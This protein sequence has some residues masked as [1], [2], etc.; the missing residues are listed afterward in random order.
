VGRAAARYHPAVQELNRMSNTIGAPLLLCLAAAGSPAPPAPSAEDQLL[1]V[2]E[3]SDYQATATH[4]EVMDLVNRLHARSDRLRVLEM[5]RTLEGRSIPLLVLADPPVASAAEARAS[6]RPIVFLLGNIHAGEVCGKEAALILARELVLAE[7]PPALLRDLVLVLAPIYNGDGNDRMSPDNRP[8]Q[9]GPARG[10]GRR[11]NAQGLDLNRD[12]VKLASPEA[13]ALVRFL[14]EWDPHLTI[15]AHT[16]NGSRHR[17]TLTYDAPLI[18][19]GHPGP[20]ELVRNRLLPEAGRRLLARTGYDTFFYGNFNRDQT[21]WE[22]YSAEPRFGA[23]Y[24]GLRGQLTVLSEAYAYAP[25]RDRV[26]CTLEFVREILGWVAEHA[27]EVRAT[28]ERARRETIEAGLAPRPDDVVGLRFRLAAWPRPAVVK[29]YRGEDAQDCSVVH[30]GRFETTLGVRRPLGYLLE[31]GLEP[32]VE[33]L[34]RHGIAVEP[35][36]GQALVERYQVTALR[37]AER[38]FQ[39]HHL[40]SLDVTCSAPRTIAAPAGSW[41]VRTAQPLGTLAV[42]LL[43]PQAE[44]GLAA[45]NFFDPHLSPGKTYPVA[46]VLGE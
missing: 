12:Y 31:P 26:L 3:A 19:A 40:V 45:W 8:G 44:D 42:Y 10:M 15:D 28:H 7:E 22:T 5:G 37:R 35:F 21:A 29:G 11:E 39:E 1:T 30:L 33:L 4:A 13:R 23:N 43:E 18:P 14:D 32:V 20:V 38:P 6:G 16:T 9:D 2:A 36:T 46:R 24:Q 17:Y 41:I 34:R 27:A 25:F